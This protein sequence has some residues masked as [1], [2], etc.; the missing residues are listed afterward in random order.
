M[1]VPLA[2]MGPEHA[3]THEDGPGPKRALGT[4]IFPSFCS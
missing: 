1:M 4:V 2:G 3:Q